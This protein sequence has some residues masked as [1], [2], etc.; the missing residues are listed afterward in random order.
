MS[1]AAF[2]PAWRGLRRAADRA[3]VYLPLVLMGIVALATYL[4]ARNTPVFG[5]APAPSAPAHVPDYL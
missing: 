3:A 5:P 1:T 2:G 4:L